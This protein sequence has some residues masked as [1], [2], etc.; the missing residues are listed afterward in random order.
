M[1]VNALDRQ[2]Q[3]KQTFNRDRIS[4]INRLKL[5]T[6]WSDDGANGE[7]GEQEAFEIQ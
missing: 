1:S 6:S 7:N 4:K 5:C 3:M 2:V